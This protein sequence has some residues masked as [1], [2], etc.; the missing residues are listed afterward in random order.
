LLL[1][2]RTGRPEAGR[3]R[4]RWLRLL[5]NQ[6]QKPPEKAAHRGGLFRILRADYNDPSFLFYIYIEDEGAEPIEGAT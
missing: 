1:H 2:R 5:V 6:I 3:L 4:L